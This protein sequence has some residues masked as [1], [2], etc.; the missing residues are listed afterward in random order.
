MS[1]T[2]TP[3]ETAPRWPASGLWFMNVLY[4]AAAGVS[5]DCRHL[6]GRASISIG[7]EVPP[8]QD[9][10][11]QGDTMASRC[12]ARLQ[13]DPQGRSVRILDCGSKNGVFVNGARTAECALHDGDIVRIGATLLQL[14]C[15]PGP[16]LDAPEAA[17]VIHQELQGTSP[18]IRALRFKIY[19]AAASDISV[20]ILG[21]SGVGKE[22]VARALHG[23]SRRPGMFVAVNSA[24]ISDGLA[25]SILFGHE[26]GAFTGADRTH[27]GL[28]R[29]AHTGTLFLDE[30]ADMPAA[31]QPKILRAVEEKAV[32]PVRAER[33]IP[34]DVRLVAA[35]NRDLSA[36]VRE[37]RFR[38]DLFARLS[39]LVLK[40]PPLRERR[41]D[42]LPLFARYLNRPRLRLTISLAERLL[43]HPWPFN[44]R[45]LVQLASGINTYYAELDEL[46]WREV[47][48][49]LPQSCE[50]PSGLAPP[51][52]PDAG[53]ALL[54]PSAAAPDL[55][56]ARAPAPLSREAVVACMQRHRGNVIQA[57]AHLGCSPRHL[58]RLLSKFGLSA[59][60]FRAAKPGSPA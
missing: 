21:E 58:R 3:Q 29:E 2:Q 38:E 39:G 19:K 10:R 60:A 50:S 24:T 49:L 23:A 56:E 32:R 22:R 26:R 14:R 46:D 17:A 27:R 47:A 30:V 52:V 53:P 36:A 16:P 9:I 20:L 28:F 8:E 12:H 25:E 11:L 59:E 51:R 34:C 1:T 41:E 37:G 43:L 44:V 33:S 42:I 57:A 7:R 54:G 45:E 55:R 40:P 13:I 31:I 15:E 5:A 4:T 6:L 35:T 48:E 18:A